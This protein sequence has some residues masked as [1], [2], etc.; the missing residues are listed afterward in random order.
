LNVCHCFFQGQL[1]C[2][3]PCPS[4]EQELHWDPQNKRR[5]RF[6]SEPYAGPGCVD[7]CRQDSKEKD[8]QTKA[9]STI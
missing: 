6:P 3:P 8:Y 9:S 7:I 1:S 5:R 4:N 2:R